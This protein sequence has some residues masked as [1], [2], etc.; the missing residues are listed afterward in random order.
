VPDE[1]VDEVRTDL[2]LTD[3]RFALG[4]R[5]PEMR[6][7]R[8][9]QPKLAE[10]DVAQDSSA[11]PQSASG[12][13]SPPAP[14]PEPASDSPS[15]MRSPP[16]TAANCASAPRATTIKPAPRPTF[17]QISCRHPEAGTTITLLLPT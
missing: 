14:A 6:A 10:P 3:A 13:L 8:R 15:S 7:G 2:H 17:S 5:D 12:K 9:V 16:P 1:F 11:T 4:V